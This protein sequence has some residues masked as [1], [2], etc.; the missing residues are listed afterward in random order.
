MSYNSPKGYHLSKL[1]RILKAGKTTVFS[2]QRALVL[3][4]ITKIFTVKA[5]MQDHLQ[6]LDVSYNLKITQ[7]QIWKTWECWHP[8]RI[9]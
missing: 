2:L 5:V 8:N 9:A 1:V 7:V 6:S 4:Y 3:D